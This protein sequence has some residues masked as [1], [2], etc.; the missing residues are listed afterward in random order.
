MFFERKVKE[1][2]RIAELKERHPDRWEQHKN[3]QIQQGQIEQKINIRLREIYS[4]RS[5]QSTNIFN[6]LNRVETMIN[7]EFLQ[8]SSLDKQLQIYRQLVFYLNQ[9][10]QFK[11]QLNLLFSTNQNNSKGFYFQSF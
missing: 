6:E 2:L 9:L 1:T 3:C 11:Q 5:D 10:A 8:T 7:E 4:A